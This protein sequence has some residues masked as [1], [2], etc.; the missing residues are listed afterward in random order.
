M[1]GVWVHVIRE[2]VIKIDV[3][4]FGNL[5]ADLFRQRRQC[6]LVWRLRGRLV[7]WDAQGTLKS[8]WEETGH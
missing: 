4:T 7:D 5:G 6:A 8:R 2:Q 3:L 1:G